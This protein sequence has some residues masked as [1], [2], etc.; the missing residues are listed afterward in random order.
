MY[1]VKEVKE[2]LERQFKIC[3][4]FPIFSCNFPTC[5]CI[6]WA[7]CYCT[8]QINKTLVKKKIKI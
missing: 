2:L 3:Y 6:Q 7:K 1:P 8:S 5:S 4:Y